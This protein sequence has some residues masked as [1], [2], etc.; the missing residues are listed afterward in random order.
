M[1][2]ICLCQKWRDQWFLQSTFTNYRA[3]KLRLALTFY[4][5]CE[6]YQLTLRSIL[7]ARTPEHLFVFSTWLLIV[8]VIGYQAALLGRHYV[9][10]ITLTLMP[11]WSWAHVSSFYF[12][13]QAFCWSELFYFLA[14]LSLCNDVFWHHE[15]ASYYIDHLIY[16][17]CFLIM[18][19]T[20]LFIF[21]FSMTLTIYLIWTSK[22]AQMD[23]IM[24][25]SGW[26]I[27]LFGNS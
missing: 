9:T 11:G 12:E 25:L 10:N 7:C 5:P 16:A 4:V 23:L 19:M 24:G 8:V 18:S 1:P 6:L 14:V 21:T 15:I 3:F 2:R 13:P 20:R 27:K 26:L 17:K 22:R